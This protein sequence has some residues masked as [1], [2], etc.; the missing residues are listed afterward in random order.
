MHD[1]PGKN[2]PL[3]LQMIAYSLLQSVVASGS[4]CTSVGALLA[5][6]RTTGAFGL[7]VAQEET[8]GGGSDA[9]VGVVLQKSE[10][11]PA[12]MSDIVCV[13]IRRVF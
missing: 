6:S 11:G 2:Q 5:P 12:C 3:H 4:M 1:C 10:G 8:E 7:S 9:T 13:M